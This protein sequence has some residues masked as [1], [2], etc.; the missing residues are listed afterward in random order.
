SARSRICAADSSPETYSVR[1]P[2]PCRLP[3]AIDVSV[4]LPMPGEPPIS[5]IEPG[6]TPPPRIRSS[7]P[8]PVDSRSWRSAFTSASRTGFAGRPPAGADLR[9]SARASSAS[10]FQAP[11]PGHCPCHL[12]DSVPQAEQTKTV[13]G[14]AMGQRTVGTR[15]DDSPPAAGDEGG[16]GDEGRR[17]GVGL[18][19]APVVEAGA[20]EREVDLPRGDWIDFWTGAEVA[21]SGDVVAEAPL[22]RIPVW[23]RRGALIVTY[24]AEHVRAGL[25]DTP[26]RERPLEATLWG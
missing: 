21:G 20:T 6:T 23:V 18:L 12:A 17:P 4:D 1:R 2:A 26:E 7:S 22:G 10:V 24:P 14:R 19:V 13:V 11:Q 8:I 16:A 5:T 3:S 15:P 25:G 9:A